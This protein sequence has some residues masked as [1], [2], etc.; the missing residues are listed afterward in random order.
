MSDGD[1][2]RTGETRPLL[3]FARLTRSELIDCYRLRFQVYC[4]KA[5]LLPETDYPN[6]LEY[7]RYDKNAIHFGAFDADGALVGTARLVRSPTLK[8]PMFQYGAP[9]D[10][11]VPFLVDPM[12]L[13]EVSRLVFRQ[14]LTRHSQP[15]TGLGP[16]QSTDK[17]TP[18]GSAPCL[19]V[20][21]GLARLMYIESKYEGIHQWIVAMER[22][23]QR[24]L[25]RIDCHFEQAGSPFE[26]WGQVIP[27]TLSVSAYE[28]AVG[29]S[30]QAQSAKGLRELP[31]GSCIDQLVTGG[32]EQDQH[33]GT[34]IHARNGCLAGE[35]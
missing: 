17:S 5:K 32:R 27:F 16:R 8:L 1:S 7:D 12:A 34:R 24:L 9:I 20:L 28:A 25:K 21:A 31:M 15:G 3:S 29:M 10:L 22:P 19:G 4:R 11:Y 26:Y 2:D 33:R 13:A 23:L 14:S 6:G 18:P 35:R 30:H